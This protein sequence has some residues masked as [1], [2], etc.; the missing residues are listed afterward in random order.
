MRGPGLVWE[1]PAWYEG[2]RPGMRGPGLVWE[3]IREHTPIT[4]QSAIFYVFKSDSKNKNTT[5]NIKCDNNP[6]FRPKHFVGLGTRG[7]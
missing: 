2:P 4:S 7:A 5:R 3:H 6:F 1:A